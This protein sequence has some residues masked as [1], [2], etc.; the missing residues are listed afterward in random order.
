M[1][2]ETMNI[3]E[4][5]RMKE[6]QFTLREIGEATG[7]SK[8]TAGEILS[9]CKECGLTYEEA[10][11]RSPERISVIHLDESRLRM[12]LALKPFINAYYPACLLHNKRTPGISDAGILTIAFAIANLLVNIGKFG[13]R[14]FQVT[15]V[16]NQYCFNT[17]LSS[18]IGLL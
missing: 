15:D 6:M 12:N 1:C 17:Y 4:I 16:R 18:R 14:G 10:I 3:S 2:L 9:R 7:C 13:M 11:K 8:T 5:L